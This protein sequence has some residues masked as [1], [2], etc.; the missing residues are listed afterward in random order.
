MV[1][2]IENIEQAKKIIEELDQLVEH[3]RREKEKWKDKAKSEET[4]VGRLL[5]I[6]RELAGEENGLLQKDEGVI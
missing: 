3:E 6:L 2:V 5:E 4:E 1:Y